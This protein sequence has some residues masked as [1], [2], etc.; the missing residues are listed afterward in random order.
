MKQMKKK[1]KQD[2]TDSRN[3]TRGEKQRT[4]KELFNLEANAQLSQPWFPKTTSENTDKKNRSSFFQEAK[5]ETHQKKFIYLLVYTTTV[6]IS[7]ISEGVS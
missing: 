4:K 6:S 3:E 5:I 7:T 2:T 1:K